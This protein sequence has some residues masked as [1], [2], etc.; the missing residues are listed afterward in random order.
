MEMSRVAAF[1]VGAAVAIAAAAPARA[2]VTVVMSGLDNPRGLAIA[3]NGALYVAEAGRGSVAGPCVFNATTGENR[4]YGPTGA[5]TRLWKGRQERVVEG[6]PSHAVYGHPNPALFPDGS[7]ASGPNGI[8]FQG[9]GGAYV[10]IGLGG[11]PGFLS[12][13][14]AAGDRMGTLIHVAASGQWRVVADVSAFEY[15]ENPDGGFLDSNPFGILAEAG[16][17]VVADAG[18]NALFRVAANGDVE[19]LA[20]FGPRPAAPVDAVPTSVA[21]GPDGAYYVGQL[22]GVPFPAG[23]ANIFRVVPGEAPQVWLSGFKAIMGI[24]FDRDGH[25]Y[26]VEHAGGPAFFPPNSGR[27]VRVATDGTRSIVASGLNRP[28]AVAIGAD[29]AIYVTNNGVVA[30][31]GQVLRITP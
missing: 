8:S 17:R 27:L 13:F 7:S 28:T 6:L 24:A 1:A 29:G 20:V 23:A 9:T 26:V 11:G 21:R 5:I 19:T 22:T 16:G 10:T 25:L 18:A 2:A 30:G 4:C 15:D 3:P 31:A 12:G 14:G